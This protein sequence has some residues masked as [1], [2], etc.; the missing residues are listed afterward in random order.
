M[1]YT[2]DPTCPE[3]ADPD[4]GVT[5]VTSRVLQNVANELRSG[6]HPLVV[7]RVGD[8]VLLQGDTLSLPDALD[9]MARTSFDMVLRVNAADGITVITGDEAYTCVATEA[10]AA[11]DTSLPE[12]ER[13]LQALRTRTANHGTDDPIAIV[14]RCLTQCDVSVFA[15]IEQ[16]DI[17]LQDPAQHDRPDRERVA[18]LQLALRDAAR[19]G[20]YRNTCVIIAG[21]TT[22]IPPV[23]L[24][25]SEEIGVVNMGAPTRAERAHFLQAS[26]GSMH[27]ADGLAEE[28]R[29][30][31]VHELASLTDGESLSTLD[32]LVCFSQFGR[33]SV[34]QPRLLVNLHRFGDRPD[35]WTHLAPQLRAVRASLEAQVYGQQAAIDAV[36][37][38]LAAAALGLDFSGNPLGAE[39]QPRGVLWFVGPT[40]VGKTRLAKAIAEAV[41]GDSD[42]YIRLDMTTFAR[43]H[44]A[45]RL[46]GAPPG[47]VGFERG[48]ELTNAVRQRPNSVI[49]LDEIEKAH[50]QV[51]ERFMSIF[52]DGRITDAQGRVTYFSETIIIATS[53]EG[54]EELSK[55]FAREGP[56]VT[57]EQVADVSVAAVRGYFE[58]LGR[59]EIFGRIAGGLVPFDVL[60]DE[61]IDRIATKFAADASFTNGPRIEVDA[62]SFC[63]MARLELS[64]PAQRA[65]GG[66][67]VRNITQQRFRTFARWLAA[68]GYA[69]AERVRVSFDGRTMLAAVDGAASAPVD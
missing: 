16:A 28:G 57:Y 6:R 33:H 4:D 20:R 18:A 32:S 25:G 48:G 26:I 49:L 46:V 45:E 29:G 54:S 60:R 30:E 61:M 39:G 41:F 8:R 51:I 40:G 63:T 69:G 43:E 68:N 12:R 24:S 1:T 56:E 50:P 62:Q 3:V 27:A 36:M 17:V 15:T 23:L 31:L 14:R 11:E 34:L 10:P 37:D 2:T 9:R 38:A 67:Q 19:V 55:L 44:S 58:G 53:N 35:Y 47:Y 5:L 22:G 66:R 52:D 7:G 64:D 21:Q 65:L 13:R 42:A 59:P